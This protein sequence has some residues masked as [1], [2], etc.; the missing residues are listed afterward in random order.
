MQKP[1]SREEREKLQEYAKLV[2]GALGGAMTATMIYLGDKLGLY[3]ALAGAGPVTSAELAQKTGLSERWLREWLHA[4]GAAG[5]LAHH[6][7]DR[8]SLSP[9]G[10]AVLANE[11]HP[12]FGAGFFS[13]LPTLMGVADRIPESFRTGIGLPYDALGPEGARGIE[14]G[15]APW[16]RALL[17][18]M[19]LPRVGDVVKRLRSGATAADVGCGAGVAL[20]EMAKA[21]P[22]S[23]FHGYDIS[24]FA[25]ARA[26]ENR[27]AAGARNASFHDAAHDPLP[28][29]GRFAF[30]TTFDCLHDMTDPAGV[31]RKIRAA[32]APDGTW[33][34]ADIKAH[35]SYQENV[36]KNP[37]A[38]MMYG[39]SVLACMSSA[40]S[41]PGGLG[42]G[43]LGFT[44]EM[45][46]KMTRE[47]G[48]TRFEAV[49]FDHPINAFYVVRA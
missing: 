37:M 6:E 10:V 21:F 28:G 27:A 31:M 4:Q 17:V 42:L 5:V 9:E 12:A 20:L 22:K 15:L 34:I 33:L 1:P 11:N 38:A 43:T 13:Q 46:R 2:F 18:P 19:V 47:A 40:L 49:D 32:L 29:D 3:Q 7:G 44:E 26:E 45:A 25:L 30:V 35:P 48:F 39:T 41:E 14:R 36:E 23:E 24:R 8:F 16:F